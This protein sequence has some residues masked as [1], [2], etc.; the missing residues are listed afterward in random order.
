MSPYRFNPVAMAERPHPFP[1]RTRKLS[2]LAPMVLHGQ[3]CGRVGRRRVIFI[4]SPDHYHNGQGFFVWGRFT[5]TLS[6]E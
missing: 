3:L 2:S 4:Q 1:S 6:F 5:V